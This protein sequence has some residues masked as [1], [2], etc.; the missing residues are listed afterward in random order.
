[1]ADMNALDQDIAIVGVACRMPGGATNL[2]KLWDILREG[3]SCHSDVPPGRYNL[4]A[5]R[6]PE[7]GRRNAITAN[8]AHFL[9]EDI[10]AWDSVFFGCGP[11]D[12]RSMDPQQR[13]MLEVA[14]EA[15]ESAGLPIEDLQGSAT[16]CFVGSCT[17]D[18]C[19]MQIRDPEQSPQNSA[20]GT[21]TSLISNKISWFYDL[22][23]PS[24]TLDTACSSGLVALHLACQSLR[25]G[26]ATVALCGGSN[27]ILS[28]DLTMWFSN[29]HFLAADG[30]S[31]PFD[32]GADGYGRGEG[33]GFVVLKPMSTAIRDGDCVR[34]VIRGTGSN[35][36][37]RTTGITLPSG[38]AQAELIESTYAKSG[39][40]MSTTRYF[41]AHGTG[42]AA[43][44]PIEMGAIASCF[45]RHRSE[46]EPLYIGSAKA[47]IG[48]LEGAAGLAGIL[49]T[50][51]IL[52]SG[53]IPQNPHFA[54]F[55]SGLGFSTT[56]LCVAKSTISWPSAGLRRVSVNGFGMGGTNGH[57]ILDDAGHYFVER[58]IAGVH[59]TS[60]EADHS[61]SHTNMGF[62][63]D[64]ETD[65]LKTGPCDV[66]DRW[67]DAPSSHS[68][69][70]SLSEADS[71]TAEPVR[72]WKEGRSCDGYKPSIVETPSTPSS[73]L[74]RD[75]LPDQQLTS[76]SRHIF[77]FSAQDQLGLERVVE[78]Y[79]RYFDSH[80]ARPG[81]ESLGGDYLRRLSYTLGSRRSHLSWRMFRTADSL[82]GLISA[83]STPQVA[84]GQAAIHPKIA[85]VFTGQGA[86]WACMGV[87]LMR[88]KCYRNSIER[89]EN[90]LRHLGCTWSV[91]SVLSAA[92]D[93]SK[94]SSPEY[95]QPLCTV[96]QL[97]LVNLLEDWGIVP[98]YV[99]G[100]SSGEIAAAYAHGALSFQDACTLAYHRGRVC[101]LPRLPFEAPSQRGAMMAVGLSATE[102]E[103]RLANVTKGQIVVACENSPT[104]VTIS[105]DE[106]A[107]DELRDLLESESIFAR[108][109]KVTQAYHSPHMALLRDVYSEAISEVCVQ[110]P[111]TTTKMFSSVTGDLIDSSELGPQYWVRNLTQPVMFKQAIEAMMRFGTRRRR[112]AAVTSVDTVVEV[113]PHAALKGPIRK[114]MEAQ[115]ISGVNYTSVLVRGQDD[116]QSA[117]ECVGSL[118]NRG[119]SVA[120]SKVN[121]ID[122]DNLSVMKPIMDLPQYPWDHSKSFWSETRLSRSYRFRKHAQHSL[123]GA[124]TSD[125]SQLEPRWRMFI[126]VTEKPWVRD[127]TI[128]GAMVYPAAGMIAMAIEAMRQVADQT[129]EISQIFLRDVEISKA[130]LVPDTEEGVEVMLRLN[131]QIPIS[132][133]DP[134]YWSHFVIT[135][136]NDEDVAEENCSGLISIDYRKIRRAAWFLDEDIEERAYVRQTLTDADKANT[137]LLDRQQIYLQFHHIGM[138]YGPSFQ[139]IDSIRYG[140]QSCFFRIKIPEIRSAYGSRAAGNHCIHPATLDAVFQTLFAASF[141]ADGAMASAAV[142]SA[143]E[144]IRIS[145]LVPAA[146]GCYLTGC[147]REVVTRNVGRAF[148]IDVS[149]QG[150]EEPLVSVRGLL[151]KVIS[152][153]SSG[154]GKADASETAR[155]LKPIYGADIDMLDP[156]SLEAAL[157][158]APISISEQDL[159]NMKKKE[160]AALLFM[161]RALA[162]VSSSEISIPH[163]RLYFHWLE[164]Q[165]HVWE[166]NVSPLGFDH[167]SLVEADGEEQIFDDVEVLDDEGLA[168][169]RI[170]QQIPDIL[171]GNISALD[172]LR[173]DD[174]LKRF[175][176][177]HDLQYLSNR[178]SEVMAMMAFKNPNMSVLELGA[179]T[180][181][182]THVLLERLT[183]EDRTTSMLSDYTFT[184]ISAGYFEA[185]K[186]EFQHWNLKMSYRTLDL[187]N[188]P[189]VQGFEENS[190]DVVVASNV[191]HATKQLNSTLKHVYQLM[192]P[193]GKLFLIE[194]TKP[195][196]RLSMIFGCF[197]GWWRGEEDN[198]RHGGPT[199]L[200]PQWD[201]LMKDV[202]FSGVETVIHDTD[203]ESH[204]QYDLITTTKPETSAG[205]AARNELMIIASSSSISPPPPLV[206][207]IVSSVSAQGRIAYTIDWNDQTVDFKGKDVLSLLEVEK[208]F[209][210]DLDEV[211]FAALR[212]LCT[213]A[214]DITWVTRGS[215]PEAG[216]ATGLFRSIRQERADV[217]IRVLSLTTTYVSGPVGA[218]AA[219]LKVLNS[220]STDV[221]FYERDGILNLKRL[222]ADSASEQV[223]LQ[224]RT[225]TGSELVALKELSAPVLMSIENPGLLDTLRFQPNTSVLGALHEEGVEIEVKAVSL[226]F[227][228]V[229]VALGKIKP[230]KFGL[231][232]SGIVRAVGAAVNQFK[233]GDRVYAAGFASLTNVF[234]AS[235]KCCHPLL[236]GLSF[237]DGCSLGLVFGTVIEGLVN[238]A[239]IRSGQTVLIHCAAGGV[240]QAA[241]QV[242]K[243]YA[244]KIFVTVGSLEKKKLLMSTYGIPEDCIHN[245]RDLSFEKGIMRLTHGRGVDIVLNSLSGEALRRTWTCLA[246]QGT[247][248]E[249]GKRDI[250]ENNSLEMRPF[251]QGAVFACIALDYLLDND[252][253]RFQGILKQVFEFCRR[254]EALSINT[255]IFSI[256]DATSAFRTMQTGT[257]TGKVVLRLDGDARIPVV[258]YL[259]YS[260]GLRH[261]ATYLVVGGKSGIGRN[262]VLYL[263]SQG[264][265]HII[266]MSRSAGSRKSKSLN[267]QSEADKYGATVNALSCDIA[268]LEDLSRALASYSVSMPPIRGVIQAAMVLS[269]AVFENM[270]LDRWQASTRPKVQ[271]SWNLHQ[272]LPQGLDFFVMLSSISGVIGNPGQAN[273]AAGNTYQ[274]ALAEYRH[275]LGESAV[276]I[277]L[278]LVTEVGYV[279]E[280]SGRTNLNDNELAVLTPED[281]HILLKTAILRGKE[282]ENGVAQITC[283]LLTGRQARVK[284][285]EPPNYFSQSL[286]AHLAKMGMHYEDSP[287]PDTATADNLTSRLASATS[288]QIAI[289][290]LCHITVHKIA[291]YLNT[292]SENIDAGRPL[293][294]YGVDSLVAVEMRNWIVRMLKAEINLFDLLNTPSIRELAVRIAS[295]CQLLPAGLE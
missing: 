32:T 82:A 73:S 201:A 99:T 53:Q 185:A 206:Q 31:K 49:R 286:C 218:I 121:S 20:L 113:G 283:G 79:L 122:G 235:A 87:Q 294:M 112:A 33:F 219:I 109:L 105:G 277:N 175:Y 102:A 244:A 213:Q 198:G 154:E 158:L 95:A 94:I 104:D 265:K 84:A 257:H 108:K 116:S 170:G 96:L 92:E 228:D 156:E 80:L 155:C 223:G 222:N 270:T 165:I 100:H 74:D 110:M 28:P 221:E 114:I 153:V 40:D 133:S 248:I 115:N 180:G 161:R 249:I 117:L 174:L 237:E 137:R 54:E 70:G 126:R 274:D 289:E 287:T 138:Q 224:A 188:N 50:V 196:A 106:A 216:I 272:L 78:S 9:D 7:Q 149:D 129:K 160:T 52:E 81:A 263:L 90:Y 159:T 264:A 135:T 243:S 6:D 231:E 68:P 187:E 168:I 220:Q 98:T 59:C 247:F 254:P 93:M 60:M 14:F 12:A 152:A 229:L 284:S 23:G 241:I 195:A 128:Q 147:T 85:M 225:H 35:Q 130:I 189:L 236:P 43:G 143:I 56:K 83:L 72:S 119:V 101:S 172:I 24:V 207:Q 288:M 258:P 194:A 47:C 292:S 250:M 132:D 209:L 215:Q 88:F 125:Y 192:R 120:V 179:G 186:E 268:S 163:L 256:A 127:H 91:A 11:S 69:L 37:G 151:V 267:L 89:A 178:L 44:D 279:A 259:A 173:E 245:S 111:R 65:E 63:G 226:N 19:E 208:P 8:G 278:G 27:L 232:V 134:N 77:I 183:S 214:K 204:R 255:T 26:D 253:D 16:S 238:V 177:T 157:P 17:K 291:S 25:N 34:A 142:P 269:D 164:R 252:R 210:Q 2:S 203:S 239:R 197:E 67:N 97:A 136:Y 118:V 45:D 57:A 212:R 285:Q 124:T 240:G 167:K 227:R 148:D 71:F 13:L 75:S 275:S 266:V 193:G 182:T 46:S 4:D 64:I 76:P 48:H 42:T 150:L 230:N 58:G 18:Y 86:Q 41:E 30:R 55:S 3:T 234:R 10:A 29:V 261:D 282:V 162:S 38:Q 5:F 211:H 290:E 273:Y 200:V 233:P 166:H 184:D 205:T 21:S 66:Q 39:L 141:D 271:G 242:A 295:T 103:G 190:F 139:N 262:I 176:R 191:V 280:R 281:V 246:P 293:H 181:G 251:A 202:G 146:P 123:L 62:A 199:L 131:L 171:R 1:M 217:R 169:S 144:S 51:C 276:S 107:I 260:L 36:D 61:S 15:F 140:S 145:S 22:K